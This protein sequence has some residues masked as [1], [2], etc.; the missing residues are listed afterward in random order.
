MPS[1]T[2]INSIDELDRLKKQISQHKDVFDIWEE[3]RKNL[4]NQNQSLEVRLDAA[5]DANRVGM[6]ADSRFSQHLGHEIGHKIGTKG[7]DDIKKAYRPGLMQLTPI[8]GQLA[9]TVVGVAAGVIPGIGQGMGFAMS[10]AAAA[11]CS[12][13]ATGANAGSGVMGSVGGLVGTNQ[14][15]T[16]NIVQTKLELEK[17]HRSDLDHSKQLALQ[18]ADRIEET[19]KKAEDNRS[20]TIQ[21]VTQ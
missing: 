11:A 16:Q 19:K 12:A 21:S 5:Y 1:T 8:A 14:Q 3:T 4:D 9:L 6:V 7:V 15:G 18:S 2:S 20:R 10:T 13:V 17:S